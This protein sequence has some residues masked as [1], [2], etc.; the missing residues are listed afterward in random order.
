MK[1]AYLKDLS[2]DGSLIELAASIG[3]NRSL[4]HLD[5]SGIRIRK[6]Y[7]K[8][9]MEPALSC[10]ISLCDIVGKFPPEVLR[11]QLGINQMIRDKIYPCFIKK[12]KMNKKAPFDFRLVDP[13]NI[14]FLNI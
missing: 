11:Y 12:P 6:P 13:V 1:C 10:N 4:R 2:E 3:R 9:Y 7:L 14:S 8:K 5:L